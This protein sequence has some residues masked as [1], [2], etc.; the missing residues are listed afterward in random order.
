MQM[1][2]EDFR[3]MAL[4]LEGAEEGAHHGHADFR[5]GGKI[6]A[7]LAYEKEGAGVVMV[8]PEEQQGMVSD[9]PKM[10]TPVNGAWGK[11]GATKVHLARVTEEALKGA[12]KAAWLKAGGGK[13]GRGRASGR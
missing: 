5:V 2:A 1:T 3:R 8:T 9:A 12:L 10:F 7:T 6:F 13:R 11:K 4:R